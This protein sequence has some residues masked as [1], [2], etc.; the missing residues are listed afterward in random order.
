MNEIQQL[1]CTHCSAA[2]NLLLVGDSASHSREAMGYSARAGSV[3]GPELRKLY[4]EVEPFLSYAL[5]TDTSNGQRAVLTAASA[6]APKRL[7]FTTGASGL[8]IL[9]QICYRQKAAD[10]RLQSYFGHFLACPADPTERLRQ[11]RQALQLWGAEGWVLEDRDSLDM[12]LRP[13]GSLAALLEGRP[14]VVNDDLV[15]DFLTVPAGGAFR[16]RTGILPERWRQQSPKERQDVFK[17]LLHGFLETGVN[18]RTPVVL[19]VEPAVAA[20]LFYAILRVLPEGCFARDVTLSTYESNIRRSDASLAA[21][22]FMDPKTDMPRDSYLPGR[23]WVMNTFPESGGLRTPSRGSPSRYAEV[24]LTLLLT[25]NQG[26]QG[27]DAFL[28]DIGQAGA[29]SPGQLE[30]VAAAS[31]VIAEIFETG[32]ANAVAVN[33]D[34]EA[35]QTY[36]HNALTRQIVAG[37][38]ESAP[39]QAKL[40]EILGL[41]FIVSPDAAP[42]SLASALAHSVHFGAIVGAP[43]IPDPWKSLIIAE[44]I[45][46]TPV[47]PP[48]C[49]DMWEPAKAPV[50]LKMIVQHLDAQALTRFFEQA[51][52]KAA[53]LELIVAC[54]QARKNKDK[55]HLLDDMVQKVIE[56]TR[57]EAILV[58]FA[59]SDALAALGKAASPSLD[60]WL[61]LQVATLVRG[62]CDERKRWDSSYRLLNPVAR[63]MRDRDNQCLQAWAACHEAIGEMALAKWPNSPAFDQACHALVDHFQ[64]ALDLS[65]DKSLDASSRK[66]LLDKFMRTWGGYWPVIPFPQKAKILPYLEGKRWPATRAWSFSELAKD[67]R[68]VGAGAVLLIG[69]IGLGIVLKINTR[70]EDDTSDSGV[71]MATTSSPEGQVVM[72]EA[73]ARTGPESGKKVQPGGEP[74]ETKSIPEPLDKSKADKSDQDKKILAAQRQSELREQIAQYRKELEGKRIH[75]SKQES[76]QR[77]RLKDLDDL[78]QGFRYFTLTSRPVVPRDSATIKVGANLMLP[79]DITYSLHGFKLEREGAKTTQKPFEHTKYLVPGRTEAHA[80]VVDRILIKKDAPHFTFEVRL[81]SALLGKEVC[82]QLPNKQDGGISLDWSLEITFEHDDFVQRKLHEFETDRARYLETKADLVKAA[83]EIQDKSKQCITRI[84]DLRNTIFKQ[85]TMA[86]AVQIRPSVKEEPNS[87][88]A[89][90]TLLFNPDRPLSASDSSLPRNIRILYDLKLKRQ[91]EGDPFVFPFHDGDSQ[92]FSADAWDRLR[93]LRDPKRYMVLKERFDLHKVVIIPYLVL[94]KTSFRAMVEKDETEESFEPGCNYRLTFDLQKGEALMKELALLDKYE[95]EEKAQI[96]R[97]SAK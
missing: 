9:G 72:P 38:L 69:A 10:G 79:S 30:E 76:E 82:L 46:A 55:D 95:D 26:W 41:A 60:E 63:L 2:T 86:G 25:P 34:S 39:D 80:I 4:R 96:A 22:V 92:Q 31:T 52:D 45:K 42:P 14:A 58:R 7:L 15:L 74:K 66:I 91:N 90:S 20:L 29:S 49:S 78:F 56:N 8:S 33:R 3:Q 61:H 28:E 77:Q 81:K 83:A 53:R 1:Y 67:K 17:A 71:A 21:T 75:L 65:M 54:A 6:L 62:I 68:L 89:N 16:D 64:T 97:A 13:L 11:A 12:R 18:V 84:H 70:S 35:V 87:G 32:K 59:R 24:V 85:L 27:V 40:L 43:N 73:T 36:L 37:R 51:P 44:A 48:E 88:D 5:P 23:G 94:N 57:P 19:V 93:D 47:I 50:A